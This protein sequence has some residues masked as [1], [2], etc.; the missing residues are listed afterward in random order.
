M[1]QLPLRRRRAHGIHAKIAAR[2]GI[3]VQRK[4][5]RV[6]PAKNHQ[7]T[8]QH[9]HEG[10]AVA[11]RDQAQPGNRDEHDR[12]VRAIVQPRHAAERYQNQHHH[13]ECNR[14]RHDPVPLRR[15]APRPRERFDQQL[16]RHQQPG[17][18]DEQRILPRPVEQQRRH[19]RGKHPAQ[20][21]T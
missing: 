15:V 2:A 19:K 9:R 17:Q 12:A 14:Q 10:C 3:A 16:L 7:R 8:D 11:Q 6:K 20:R 18:E 4:H 13:R 21:P 1:R 5:R